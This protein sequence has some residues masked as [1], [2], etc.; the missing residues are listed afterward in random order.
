VA[1]GLTIGNVKEAVQVLSPMG[2]D[3]SGGVE[4]NGEK[5]VEQIKNFLAYARSLER[6]NE[7]C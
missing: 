5:S 3:V 6:G 1:G 4:I 7:E 2:I